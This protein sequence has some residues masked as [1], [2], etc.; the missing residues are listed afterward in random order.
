[1]FLLDYLKLRWA[2]KGSVVEAGIPPES[3]PDTVPV[4]RELIQR[5]LAANP[6]LPQDAASAET[7]FH[8][9]S[10][11]MFLQTG[12]R[13]LG[14]SLVAEGRIQADEEAL[15]QLLHVL[16]NEVTRRMYIDSARQR[17]G[18]IGIQLFAENPAD[19]T[20]RRLTE[21]DTYGLGPGIYPFDKVPDNPTPGRRCPFYIRVVLA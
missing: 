2:R 17:P 7:L 11:P 15:V 4:T 14:H 12:A 21:A 9:L 20:V 6:A 18:A 1:M 16:A 5:H 13:S 19:E 10:D 3:R 8:A